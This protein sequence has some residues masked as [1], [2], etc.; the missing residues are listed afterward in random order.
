MPIV[1]K[2]FDGRAFMERLGPQQERGG[3]G[4]PP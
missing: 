1:Q 3:N 2:P 4:A